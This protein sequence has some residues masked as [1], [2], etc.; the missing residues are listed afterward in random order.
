[1]GK[2]SSSSSSSST[3]KGRKRSRSRDRK[4]KDRKRSKSK[5]SESSVPKGFPKPGENR[6]PEPPA[7]VP[8]MFGSSSDRNVNYDNHD[9]RGGDPLHRP[10]NK[11]QR[12]DDPGST[13]KRGGMQG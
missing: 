11:D 10:T 2:R 6:R 8:G 7:A 13:K 12:P 4:D 5:S 9:D 1:M 3:K